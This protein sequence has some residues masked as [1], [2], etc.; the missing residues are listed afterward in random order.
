MTYSTVCTFPRVN[1]PERQKTP[2][3][4]RKGVSRIEE[5]EI[6]ALSAEATDLRD[7]SLT[8]HC[9]RFLCICQGVYLDANSVTFFFRDRGYAG[10]D[11]SRL[12]VCDRQICRLQISANFFCRHVSGSRSFCFSCGIICTDSLSPILLDALLVSGNPKTG[13]S[14]RE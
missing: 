1:A 9:S 12:N 2:L 3:R 6:R 14:P 7:G 5:K 11:G 8:H 10:A 4:A 13:R